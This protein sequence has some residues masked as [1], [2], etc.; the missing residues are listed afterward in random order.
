M[1]TL[2]EGL[3]GAEFVLRRIVDGTVVTDPDSDL[4]PVTVKSTMKAMPSLRT[5]E[6]GN[7]EIEEIKAPDGYIRNTEKISVSAQRFWRRFLKADSTALCRRR[8]Q[9]VRLRWPSVKRSVW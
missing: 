5:M 9:T 2:Q 6:F 4:A 7:Y 3:A 8:S 1:R